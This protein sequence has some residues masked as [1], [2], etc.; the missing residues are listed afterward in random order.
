MKLRPDEVAALTALA[1][2]RHDLLRLLARTV[3]EHSRIPALI[4]RIA[5]IV[6]H[7]AVDGK[8]FA[9]PGDIFD[10]SHG[11]ERDARLAHDGA[12]GFEHE[13]GKAQPVRRTA[14]PD[15]RDECGEIFPV[16]RGRDHRVALRIPDAEAAAQIDGIRFKPRFLLHF[17]DE[18]EHLL[19]RDDEGLFFKDLRADMAMEASQTQIFLLKDV[20]DDL[21]RRAARHG[22]SEFGIGRRRLHIGVRV[23]LD[24]GIDADEDVLHDLPLP[25]DRIEEV[26]FGSGVDDDRPHAAVKGVGKL[27]RELVVA[28]HDDLLCRKARLHR[29]VELAA[30]DDVRTQTFAVGDGI[31]RLAGKRLGGIQDKPVPVVLFFDGV[32]VD[33]HHLSDICLVKDIERRAELRGK[34][35][36]ICPADLQMTFFID[37]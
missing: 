13:T 7:P 3:C 9:D 21:F 5:G 32:A 1:R 20:A 10:I 17:R 22:K 27:V 11:I 4:E 25:R 23:R 31:H 34:F 36:A 37:L 6:E 26:R 14:L 15:R 28:V 29:R 24:A 19:R 12:P 33:A 30:R 35:R 16:S 2:D 18:G 8:V